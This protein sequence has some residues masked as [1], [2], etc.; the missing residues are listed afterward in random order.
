[1][2]SPPSGAHPATHAPAADLALMKALVPRAAAVICAWANLKAPAGAAELQALAKA[3]PCALQVVLFTSAV[4]VGNRAV[5]A[6]IERLASASVNP[7][8]P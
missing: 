7:G 2:S 8:E 3:H 1:M 6:E 4:E 5:L